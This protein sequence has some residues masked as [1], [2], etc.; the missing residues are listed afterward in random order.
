M[1]RPLPFFLT[2]ELAVK[3][4]LSWEF[5]V[6][7]RRVIL[8]AYRFQFILFP[9]THGHQR[10]RIWKILRQSWLCRARVG[11]GEGEEKRVREE[12]RWYQVEY[13]KV[14]S[15]SVPVHPLTA[16]PCARGFFT[17][18]C[19]QQSKQ[20]SSQILKEISKWS[21]DFLGSA[22]A[23]GSPSHSPGKGLRIKMNQD[24]SDTGYCPRTSWRMPLPHHFQAP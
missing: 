5:S 17:G 19:R 9:T 4:K 22:L 23:F 10:W 14:S 18:F 1:V 11:V 2:L 15:L 16:L 7:F 12:F 24:E 21:E 6:G 8:K 3:G 13:H 20:N